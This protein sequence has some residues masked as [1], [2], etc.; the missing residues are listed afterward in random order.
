MMAFDIGQQVVC[1][2][3]IFEGKGWIR[4]PHKPQR[5]QVYTV[6][7]CCEFEYEVGGVKSAVLLEE[8][9]NPKISVPLPS[10]SLFFGEPPFPACRFR[11]VRKTDISIFTQLLTGAPWPTDCW[12]WPENV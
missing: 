2:D 4:V 5:N 11:P 12:P 1:V 3:D 7:G 10:K 9:L 8:L 6:R